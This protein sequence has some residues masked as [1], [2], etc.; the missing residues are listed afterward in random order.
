MTD[1]AETADPQSLDFQAL[2]R[3]AATR[4]KQGREA[5][6]R[7][8]SDLLSDEGD[9]HTERE[10]NLA[11]DIL[12]HLLGEVEVKLRWELAS[13]L[14]ARDDIPETLV[15]DLAMDEIDV[16]EQ[17]LRHSPLLSD[18]TLI[19]II[20]NKAEDHQ[21]AI[22]R[23]ASVS[24][25]VSQALID[26]D[27]ETVVTVLIENDGAELTPDM[28]EALVEASRNADAYHTPLVRRGDLP[29]ALAKRL[30]GWVAAPIRDFLCDRYD[31]DPKVL[32]AELN[33]VIGG[34]MRHARARRAEPSRARLMI[35]ALAAKGALDHRFL[36]GAL[37]RGN[38]EIFKEGLI[39]M[40]GLPPTLIERI[41]HDHDPRGLAVLARVIG[42]DGGN[43]LSLVTLTHPQSGQGYNPSQQERRR[44]QDMYDAIPGDTAR[45]VA[46]IW[47]QSLDY[48]LGMGS[49][50]D[51]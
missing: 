47:R 32:D 49:L 26:T 17:V 36:L 44:L 2:V 28:L 40:T 25:L 19:E 31:I 30:Y 7:T 33:K 6:F 12:R 21:I 35:E 11:A 29:E 14:A 45:E 15:A 23:R 16:A 46:R 43:F 18:L 41:L 50:A 20:H 13:R 51:D 42:A 39:E 3:L 38:V 5:V 1:D 34:E 9:L 48:S 27:N 22:A 8:V 24:A 37:H 4:S 10:R